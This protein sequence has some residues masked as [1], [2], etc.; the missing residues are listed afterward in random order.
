MDNILQKYDGMKS[1]FFTLEYSNNEKCLY[2]YDC[3]FVPNY[4]S[5]IIRIQIMRIIKVSNLQEIVKYG[6]KIID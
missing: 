6:F 4:N 5:N 1:E 2:L 3:N